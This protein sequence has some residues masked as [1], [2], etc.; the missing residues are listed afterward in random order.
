MKLK[1]IAIMFTALFLLLST[2]TLANNFGDSS[3]QEVITNNL[4]E[5]EGFENSDTVTRFEC[6]NAI[7]KAIGATEETALS[8]AMLLYGCLTGPKENA[9]LDGDDIV[10]FDYAK[11]ADKEMGYIKLAFYNE[12]AKGEIIQNRRYFYFDRPV[13]LKETSAFM[14]R[15][16]KGPDL[17]DLDETF[18][19]AK[20][21]GLIKEDDIFYNNGDSSI[22]LDYFC[23]MLWRFLNQNRY[24]YFNAENF[25]TGLGKDEDRSMTYLEYLQPR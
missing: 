17:N 6:V 7:I 8:A 14:M 19:M 5:K 16:L 9:F 15:C 10:P 21:Y 3:M 2:T 4:I 25:G 11:Y 1:N 24:L 13:T 18:A 12:L 20:E 23:T 22:T